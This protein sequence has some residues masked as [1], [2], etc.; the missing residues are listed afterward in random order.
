M[1]VHSNTCPMPNL[2]LS[3]WQKQL[4]PTSKEAPNKFFFL[5]HQ[6][7]TQIHLYI[8]NAWL[9]SKWKNTQKNMTHCSQ[10]D[11]LMYI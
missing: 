11:N 6:M 8:I 5:T 2:K 3:S 9:S 10:F 4:I 7:D 1:P